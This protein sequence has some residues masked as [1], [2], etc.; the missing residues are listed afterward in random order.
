L[1]LGQIVW[2]IPD[3]EL[4]RLSSENPGGNG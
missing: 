1:N 3:E 4:D 2:L